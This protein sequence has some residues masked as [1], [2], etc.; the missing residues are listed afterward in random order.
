M[1]MG[2]PGNTTTA[3]NAEVSNLLVQGFKAAKEGRRDE[4]Y[5]V[6][7]DVVRRDPNNELGWLYRAATTEDLSEAY[8]CLQKVLAIN[9]GNEKAQRGV[10]RIQNRLSTE[11]NSRN[12]TAAGVAAASADLNGA[13][14]ASPRIGTGDKD[15][16]SGFNPGFSNRPAADP[17]SQPTVRYPYQAAASP[18]N[19]AQ[20]PEVEETA[21]PPPYRPDFDKLKVAGISEKPSTNSGRANLA[22][23]PGKARPAS[24]YTSPNGAAE[25]N[26]ELVDE[27]VAPGGRIGAQRDATN[28]RRAGVVGGLAQARQRGRAALGTASSTGPDDSG[29]RRSRQIL[30]PLVILGVILVIAALLLLLLP[31]LNPKSTTDSTSLAVVPATTSSPVIATATPGGTPPGANNAGSLTVPVIGATTAAS[32]VTTAASVATTA[33]ATTTAPTTAPATSVAP[34]TTAAP[35]AITT[36]VATT[37]VATTAPTTQAPPPP[38]ATTAPP[39]AP[40]LPRAAVYVIKSGDNLTRIAGQFSTSIAAI[41]AAN[42]SLDIN[43][44][45]AGNRI[46][47]PVSRS[48]FRGKGGAILGPNETLQTL[49]DRYK[50][51]VDD[52]A[53]FNGLTSPADAKPGDAILI[54]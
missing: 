3:S 32:P 27:P 29:Q 19:Q 23:P 47:I 46:V 7:C 9:P 39:A 16:I 6:F 5:E 11:A 18:F 37:V 36:A 15:V 35:A 2:N 13:E 53:R 44:I 45:F 48:D 17:P 50:V 25:N 12:A 24:G 49:A 52:L 38:P 21:P 40:P 10:E 34:A 26:E 42:P 54:P 30:L 51:S 20:T 31:L 28:S 43:R 8:V 22:S 14:T 4:A 33:P 41:A 1:S